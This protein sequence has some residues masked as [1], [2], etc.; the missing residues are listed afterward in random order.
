MKRLLAIGLL[1][2]STACLAAEPPQ[3]LTLDEAV[4]LALENSPDLAAAAYRVEIARAGLQQ[5]EAAFWPRVRLGGGYAASDNPV[6]AFMMTLSQRDF[7][8]NANF[9]N[10]DVTDHLNGQVAATWSLYNGGRD[11][12]W[13]QAARLGIAASEHSLAAARQDLVFEVTRAFHTIHKARGFVAAAAAAVGSMESNVVVATERVAAGQALKADR[14]D[15]EVRLA[16]AREGLVN[17]HNALALAET[18]FGNV[19]GLDS[20]ASVTAVEPAASAAEP[21]DEADAVRPEWLAAR[22]SVAVAEKQL[23]AA[24]GGYQPQVNAFASYDLD[25]GDARHYAD[26]WMAGVSVRVD[27]FDGFLT[28]GQVAEARARLDVARE[29]L[30]RLELALALEQKQARLNLDAAAARL[31]TTVRAV[32]QAQE[33]L[34]IAQDRYA[35]GLALLTQ[36]LDAE[37]ALTGARQRRVAAETDYQVAVAALARA[38]GTILKETE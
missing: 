34:Q 25:S 12:A 22:N 17:A 3:A 31:E 24:R 2:L 32:V 28:K 10:P 30:R 23:R 27:L 6:Q 13:R 15:A 35:E 1:G 36:V 33:S 16:E 20:S 18:V 26:S 9:N 5:T 14:L 7:S 38:R 19:I 21:V 11:L 8:F 29:E 4:A 37:S